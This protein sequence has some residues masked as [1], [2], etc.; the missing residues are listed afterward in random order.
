M[1]AAPNPI[2]IGMVRKSDF[3]SKSDDEQIMSKPPMEK[4][5]TKQIFDLEQSNNARV[6]DVNDIN[7]HKHAPSNVRRIDHSQNFIFYFSY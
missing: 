5:L 3:T 6:H 4:R 7:I 1:K 2:R